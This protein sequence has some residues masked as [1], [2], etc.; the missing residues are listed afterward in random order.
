MARGEEVQ[1]L[2][3]VTFFFQPPPPSLFL[4]AE[5]NQRRIELLQLRPNL[6]FNNPLCMLED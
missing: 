6:P 4:A 2:H 3:R 1:L 5:G